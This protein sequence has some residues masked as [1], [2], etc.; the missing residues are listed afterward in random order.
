MLQLCQYRLF[1]G[2]IWNSIVLIDCTLS[3]KALVDGVAK[4][5]VDE[6]EE[7]EEEGGYFS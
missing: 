6:E 4:L 5:E 1:I 7:D 2:E 3:F